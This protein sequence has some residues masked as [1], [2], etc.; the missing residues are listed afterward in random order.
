[1]TVFYVVLMAVSSL[2]R[3]SADATTDMY[4]SWPWMPMVFVNLI[5]IDDK[6]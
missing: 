1:M 3:T 2:P 5:D 6:K 4:W